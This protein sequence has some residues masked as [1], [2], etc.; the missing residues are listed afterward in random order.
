MHQRAPIGT[1]L[2]SDREISGQEVGMCPGLRAA[3]SGYTFTELHKACME[4][5]TVHSL[6]NFSLFL[7][8]RISK[9]CPR[10]IGGRLYLTRG[11][12]AKIKSLNLGNHTLKV[13]QQCHAF[14]NQVS[15]N[16][17]QPTE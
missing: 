14:V 9:S 3:L 15:A 11:T 7:V 17:A 4:Q 13:S 10:D 6:S 1:S 8:K 2:R 16:S 12:Q 5:V